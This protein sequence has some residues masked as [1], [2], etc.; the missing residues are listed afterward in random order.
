MATDTAPR[1]ITEAD[2]RKMVEAG[3]VNIEPGQDLPAILT[4]AKLTPGARDFLTS[5]NRSFAGLRGLQEP[6]VTG[7]KG[8]AL[9]GQVQRNKFVFLENG[10]G[11]DVK[12]EAY[13]H[14][15]GNILVA[16]DHRRIDLRGM[17]DHL[18]S[19]VLDAQVVAAN[20]GY[21]ALKD[22]LEE[23]LTC[24]RRVLRAEVLEEPLPEFELLGLDAAAVRALSHDPQKTFGVPHIVP[25]WGHG[26]VLA[27]VNTLRTY[28]RCVERQAVRAFHHR[29][30]TGKNKL[31]TIE[32]EDI[33][34]HLNRLSSLFYILMLR[35]VSGYYSH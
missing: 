9:N 27:K 10:E 34:L 25:N 5:L 15:K 17:L 7:D 3:E 16:K 18:Q 35:F 8:A 6:M 20:E 11:T 28:S 1:I 19:F 26:P 12:P 21:Y 22:D 13:T 24:I 4:G 30:P 14:L 29:D 2:L 31:G 33:I 32:R 23:T